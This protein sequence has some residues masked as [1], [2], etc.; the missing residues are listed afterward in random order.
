MSNRYDFVGPQ[1]IADP[2]VTDVS[3]SLPAVTSLDEVSFYV[4]HT[5]VSDLSISVVPP[6]GNTHQIVYRIGG[7]GDDLGTGVDDT[8]RVRLRDDAAQRICDVSIPLSHL[9]GVYRPCLYR[10]SGSDEPYSLPDGYQDSPLSQF[11][12]QVAGVWKLRFHDYEGGDVGTVQAASLFATL[13]FDPTLF[14]TNVSETAKE[15]WERLGP[16]KRADGPDTSWALLHFCEA[17]TINLAELNDV[18]RDQP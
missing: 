8:Q 14:P 17:V 13:A 15:L 2:G 7:T 12:P 11:G 18:I 10:G 6:D 16:W 3:F 4:T 9:P 1:V 5:Y